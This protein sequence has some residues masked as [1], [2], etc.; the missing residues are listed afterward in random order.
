MVQAQHTKIMRSLIIKA[1]H[2]RMQKVHS[3]WAWWVAAYIVNKKKNGDFC[4]RGLM[5]SKQIFT[6][7]NQHVYRM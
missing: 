5:E 3:L 4:L 7:K 6:T 2:D 1:W